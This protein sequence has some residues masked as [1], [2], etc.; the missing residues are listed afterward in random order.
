MERGEETAGSR[1]SVALPLRTLRARAGERQ[2]RALIG[3]AV[4]GM[5]SPAAPPPALRSPTRRGR[6]QR[7]SPSGRGLGGSHRFH[8][9]GTGR[10]GTGPGCCGLGRS[11]TRAF[12]QQRNSPR[13]HQGNRGGSAAPAARLRLA[14]VPSSAPGPAPLGSSR[15]IAASP[16]T[17]PRPRGLRQPLRGGTAVPRRYRGTQAGHGPEKATAK[18]W[19][20]L[21]KFHF[22][23]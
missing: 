17:P 19:A 11:P 13:P 12:V 1:G 2:R 23:A 5:P 3:S 8:T 22:S 4:T 20:H 21:H 10:D 18:A 16:V 7:R 15:A 9:R 14:P 6:G